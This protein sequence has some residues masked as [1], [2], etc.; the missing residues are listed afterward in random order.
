LSREMIDVFQKVEESCY[1][2]TSF[3]LF[4]WKYLN[5]HLIL[6]SSRSC[7]FFFKW[8]KK[9]RPICRCESFSSLW[10]YSFMSIYIIDIHPSA[11]TRSDWDWC[12]SITEMSFHVIDS[13]L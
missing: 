12:L 5:S 7:F 8:L 10:I 11:G 1:S 13:R 3:V 2:S 9:W 6:S 4:Q